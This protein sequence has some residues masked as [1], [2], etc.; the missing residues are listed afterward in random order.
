VELDRF[1]E[2]YLADAGTVLTDRELADLEK[3]VKEAQKNL[4]KRDYPKAIELAQECLREECH[5]EAVGEA[6]KVLDQVAERAKIGLKD[7]QKK[8]AMRDKALDG[9]VALL[10]LKETF[11][12][13]S[14]A[15]GPIADAVTSG[16]QDSTRATLFEQAEVV[17]EAR[18]KEQARQFPAAIES[19][20]SL[21]EKF[22]DSPGAELA[23]R[24]IADLAKKVPGGARAKS[25]E[26]A[27]PE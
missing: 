12:G 17:R 7:A 19:W 1:L 13:H 6:R 15:A 16:Q 10:D 3:L 25:P 4:K 5:A 2:K 26:P 27:Q 14:E 18:A 22:P 23:R 9:A 24:R 11:A 8:L 21:V 20:Q